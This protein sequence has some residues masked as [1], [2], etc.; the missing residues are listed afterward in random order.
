MLPC[1][2]VR[3]CCLVATVSDVSCSLV[4][5]ILTPKLTNMSRWK[6][7]K[8][9]NTQIQH[10][11]WQNICIYIREYIV[12]GYVTPT[13]GGGYMYITIGSYLCCTTCFCPHSRI[14]LIQQIQIYLWYSGPTCH[15]LISGAQ[16]ATPT[17]SK[18]PICQKMANWA[19]KSAG[20]NFPPNRRWGPICRGLL[21]SI[22]RLPWY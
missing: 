18:G 22:W 19:P 6:I 11:C 9:K 10:H 2:L 15:C 16:F 1:P 21:S 8:E 20:P 14:Y 4:K 5:P 3:I 12:I 17:I 13:I 7:E